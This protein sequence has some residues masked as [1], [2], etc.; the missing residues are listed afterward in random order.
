MTQ[1]QAALH[2]NY[3]EL[4]NEMMLSLFKYLKAYYNVIINEDNDRI[5]IIRK[6]SS[7][8]IVFKKTEGKNPGSITNK[9]YSINLHRGEN[10]FL[11]ELDLTRII[12]NNRQNYTWYLNSPANVE[13][14]KL[15][16]NDQSW[17]DQIPTD[18]R[19]SVRNIRQLIYPTEKSGIVGPK[20]Y[21]LCENSNRSVLISR[22]VKK[23]QEA[24]DRHI[25]P[26]KVDKIENEIE[27]VCKNIDTEKGFD[28]TDEKDA[29]TKI[30]AS[31]AYRRG[32]SEFR[33]KLIIAYKSK[34]AITGSDVEAAL[35][36]AHIL[37]FKGEHTNVTENG[38]LLRS[39]IH[40]LFDLYLITID[41]ENK[42]KL[43]ES[44]KSSSHYRA[45]NDKPLFIPLDPAD[46]PNQKAL[47]LHRK[48]S[49]KIT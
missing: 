17:S 26:L 42:V 3:L 11:F 13:N 27:S 35:E 44:L 36:A 22:F 34:C 20:G 48:N 24:I 39:D 43:H 8:N 18:Y 46:Q 1:E 28:P 2:E 29:R 15:L 41:T 45:L 47:N 7:Y 25:V 14:R 12:E 9:P 37:P 40:T 16:Q 31:I 19:N 10:N 5:T 30:L 4:G 21:C 38:L 49:E 6:K 33:K 32:Q 23:M